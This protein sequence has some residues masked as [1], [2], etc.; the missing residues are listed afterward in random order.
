[1]G[2]SERGWEKKIQRQSGKCRGKDSDGMDKK[3][4]WEV[5]NGNKQGG[6]E[7]KWT[8]IV[9]TGKTVRDYGI[10]NEEAWVRENARERKMMVRFRYGNE[11]NENRY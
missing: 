6:A 5:L 3:N 10:V 8:H 2:R 1:L 11:E 4:G 7:G 9:S